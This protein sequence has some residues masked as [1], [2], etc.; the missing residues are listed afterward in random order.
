MGAAFTIGMKD[1][2]QRL[3]DRSAWIIAVI[4]P[5]G[6][7]FILNA[8]IG[9]A[10]GSE[11]GGFLTEILV[12]DDDGG[13]VSAA[14][15]DILDDLEADEIVSVE[16][17]TSAADA[18]SRV[19]DGFPSAI[20][21]PES[22]TAAAQQGSPATITVYTNPDEQI[23]SQVALALAQG[24]AAEINTV[25]LSVASVF[26]GEGTDP[27][28][29][30]I[31]G[32][33]AAAQGGTPLATVAGIETEGEGFDLATYFAIGMAVFF[34]F[35]TV[36]FGVLGLIEERDQGTMARLLAAPI[37]RAAIVG[38]KL[39]AAFVLGLVSMLVLWI[40]SSLVMGAEWGNPVGVIVLIVAGVIAAMGVTALVAAFART[41]EQAGGY[42]AIVAVVLGLLGGTFFPVS[43]ASGFF[44]LVSKIAPHRWLMD[45]FNLLTAG[46]PVSAVIP[47]ALAAV[48]FGVVTGVIGLLMAR[49]MVLTS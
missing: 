49:K 25:Q 47:S 24:F 44:S 3:R 43:Q 2:R 5:L 16:T 7:A 22:F 48:A 6:L 15:L 33:V 19:Q 1:L 39:I 13:E 10:A 42:A 41:A 14:F 21:I 12:V 18:Q 17:A 23:A 40:A 9:G 38:G 31:P 32:L 11:G 27:D 28:P 29:V 37:P 30:R 46:D 34:V 45:G 8:T 20:V 26:V 4:V 35:F 36:Q